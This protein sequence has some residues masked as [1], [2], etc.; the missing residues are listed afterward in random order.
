MSIALPRPASTVVLARPSARGFEVFL[1]RRQ[2]SVA[3]MGG[4]HVFPGGRVDQGDYTVDAEQW[5]DGSAEAA[6]R[7]DERDHDGAL[8]FHVA[9]VRELFEEASV[10]LARDGAGE[11]VSIRGD[12]QERFDVY[13]RDLASGKLPLREVA[14][15]EN[16]RLALDR[17]AVFA[18]WITPDIETRRF[19]T[20]FFFALAPPGQDAAHDAAETSD[21]I[22]VTPAEATE[23]CLRG[24]I[25]LPPPTW[26]TL[27]AL[28]LCR[29][30]NA[31]WQWART[32]RL[33]RIQP[34]V[35]EHG[36]G[37]R[38]IVLPGDSEFPAVAGFQP[39][40]T[41]FLLKGGRWRPLKMGSEV[42]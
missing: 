18:H 22:W 20:Y 4:A 28:A 27:R 33:P 41:R 9:A 24:E 2:D 16:L 14:A 17:L 23:R 31:A 6:A 35:L 15:R 34:R 37:T 38:E 7:L 19:D 25:A 10:L 32:Q 21:G 26:T 12:A 29:D 40:E 30:V 13:R 39:R 11:V 3:F 5:C 36:D 8:A 1:V 42:I